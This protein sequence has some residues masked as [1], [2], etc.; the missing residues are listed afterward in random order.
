MKVLKYLLTVALGIS[1]FGYA[2]EEP[3]ATDQLKAALEKAGDK[4]DEIIKALEDYDWKGAYEDATTFGPVSLSDTMING[5][6]RAQAVMPGE[7]LTC[8]TTVVAN[9]EKMKNLKL[10]R[11]LI[12]FKD[13][14]PQAS[15][16]IPSE[17]D[18]EVKETFT[19]TAPNE[20]GLYLIRYRPVASSSNNEW[21]D[22]EGNAPDFTHTIGIIWVRS[23]ATKA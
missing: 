20:P 12:G 6:L 8:E 22:A 15:F 10:E 23:P 13:V 18:K 5:K 1:S 2:V 19:L 21:L 17:M 9:K 11:V 4:I 14:G 7:K 16:A 3:T